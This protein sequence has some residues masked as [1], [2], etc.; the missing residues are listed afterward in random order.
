MKGAGAVRNPGSTTSE[1]SET[2]SLRTVF[3]ASSNMLVEAGL[4]A[5][6]VVDVCADE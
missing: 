3:F 6:I 5:F 4:P 2:S 1:H